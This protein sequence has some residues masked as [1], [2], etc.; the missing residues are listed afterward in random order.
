MPL[1]L[2]PAPPRAPQ[3]TPEQIQALSRET[4]TREMQRQQQQAQPSL[5]E[6]NRRAQLAAETEQRRTQTEPEPAPEPKVAEQ[7]QGDLTIG[8]I[9]VPL[10]SRVR[11]MTEGD[12]WGTVERVSKNQRVIVRTPDGKTKTV[13]IENLESAEDTPPELLDV[14]RGQHKQNLAD[15]EAQLSENPLWRAITEANG[16][17]VGAKDWADFAQDL[18]PE[19]RKWI[20]RRRPGEIEQSWD[21]V[22]ASVERQTGSAVTRDELTDAIRVIAKGRPKYADAVRQ[23]RDE[24]ERWQDEEAAR[25]RAG[26]R[27]EYDVE[28]APLADEGVEA[29]RA[30]PTPPEP[31]VEPPRVA[32]VP[33]ETEPAPRQ[34]EMVDTG[35][36]PVQQRIIPKGEPRQRSESALDYEDRVRR[37]QRQAVLE[38]DGR[39]GGTR[40]LPGMEEEAPEARPVVTPEEAQAVAGR[41]EAVLPEGVRVEATTD[42]GYRVRSE[43]G[44]EGRVR[45]VTPDK[46][47]AI[48]EETTGR[49][50]TRAR[51]AYRES[52][53]D[54][55]GTLILS[56][57]S[58]MDTI[59]HEV[60]HWLRDTGVVR[61]AEFKAVM[62]AEGVAEDADPVARE[63][64]F[65]EAYNRSSKDQGVFGR[66]RDFFAELL[67]TTR[68]QASKALKAIRGEGGKRAPG[69]AEGEGEPRTLFSRKPAEITPEEQR[70]R[71][72]QAMLDHM[73]RVR[74]KRGPGP[75][76]P[77]YVP[78]E[79][80]AKVNSLWDRAE[81][82]V[83]TPFRE[84]LNLTEKGLSSLRRAIAPQGSKLG[85]MVD[86]IGD[87]FGTDGWRIRD[88]TPEGDEYVRF[89]R[90][91]K[92]QDNLTKMDVTRINRA[93]ATALKEKG[94]DPTDES[95]WPT[96]TAALENVDG[97]EFRSLPAPWQAQIATM[98]AAIDS[99][100]DTSIDVFGRASRFLAGQKREAL[101]EI[102][103]T[104]READAARR[105]IE[106]HYDPRL[107][108]LEILT[109]AF[110][111]ERGSYLISIPKAEAAGEREGFSS[112]GPRA[113][114]ARW[115]P[116]ANKYRIQ[117]VQGTQKWRTIKTFPPEEKDAAEAFLAET[118][119]QAKVDALSKYT[120]RLGPEDLDRIANKNVRMKS[121]IPQEVRQEINVQNPFHLFA[122]SM[123]DTWHNIA[124]TRLFLHAL[125]TTARRMPAEQAQREGYE[126]MEA[127]PDMALPNTESLWQLK[128]LY[129][130]KAI[131]EDLTAMVTLPAEINQLRQAYEYVW[132]SAMT[133]G[134]PPTHVHNTFGN[135][136]FSCL[137]G[138]SPFT[139]P[140]VFIDACAELVRMHR[141]SDPSPL[142]RAIIKENL[143]GNEQY[144]AEL[145]PLYQAVER[146]GG[147]V[148]KVMANINNAMPAMLKKGWDVASR[149]YSFEDQVFKLNSVKRHMLKGMT[150]EQAIK[151]MAP[152]YPDYAAVGKASRVMRSALLGAPFVSF[153]DQWPRILA[154]GVRTRPIR[155]ATWL[156]MPGIVSAIGIWRLGLTPEEKRLLDMNRSFYDVVT[157]ERDD[158]GRPILLSLKR[159]AP[160]AEMLG[161]VF[162]DKDFE[163]PYFLQNPI[164]NAAASTMTG[165]DTFTKKRLYPK[166]ASVEQKAWASF[167]HALADLAPVPSIVRYGGP[168]IAGYSSW[169][170][171]LTGGRKRSIKEMKGLAIIGGLGGVNGRPAWVDVKKARRIMFDALSDGDRELADGIRMAW[172]KL[173]P[174]SHKVIRKT[175]MEEN[176]DAYLR[177]QYNRAIEKAVEAKQ[178]DNEARARQIVKDYN[179]NRPKAQE[180]KSRSQPMEWEAVSEAFQA[181]RAARKTR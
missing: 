128:G 145:E 74:E 33:V 84:A 160:G 12:G 71:D 122:R 163:W 158:E 124:T 142:L 159:I 174:D 15:Y 96:L 94:R 90:R 62:R 25:E 120:T 10:G 102:T 173:K 110:R 141:H 3:P 24:Y 34:P 21:E 81:H 28:D 43:G 140:R 127:L 138:T 60:A 35:R 23:V 152:A 51:G 113:R 139:G 16:I 181:E 92:G 147:S 86:W 153:A 30:Q 105:E 61:D 167:K 11:M 40:R 44:A 69:E 39:L 46:L 168:R 38:E 144:G 59:D 67:G 119:E 76:A 143:I 169:T 4:A 150:Q 176:Y 135:V 162:G 95:L 112:K 164:V 111:D 165:V 98:R 125:E 6:L 80:D 66:I 79:V 27:G 54:S 171:W 48:A 178:A 50:G 41:L 55:E 56:P 115:M 49:P 36:P 137:E 157:G 13:K 123:E 47:N 106:Q 172:N 177:G 1:E 17:R 170:N 32:Q 29:P 156:A 63:E 37:E 70:R 100:S 87:K 7:S 52:T 31:F 166:D 8:D 117:T 151:T 134:S 180:A 72:K 155:A 83:D 9:S 19:M 45:V 118:L 129:V 146:A 108:S 133:V 131:H 2:E 161:Y 121:P 77:E 91:V 130:P 107:E 114:T 53:V 82:V 22:L 64:A 148:Q 42:G 109:N 179:R 85:I 65:A 75:P 73:A 99:A 57:R 26:E 104:G 132:K 68:G 149:A 20:K 89:R 58:N 126:P 18:P 78:P 93:L 5:E 14:E 88:T 103:G 154:H 175:E 136:I 97:P 116:K 101:A